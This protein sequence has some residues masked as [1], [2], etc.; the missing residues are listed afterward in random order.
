MYRLFR[1][2]LFKLGEERA[3]RVG[4]GAARLVQAVKPDAIEPLFA[5]DHEALRQTCWGLEFPNPVGLAAGF[6]KNARLTRFW[7][8]VGFGFAEVGSVS[9]RPAE[10]NPR[11]RAFRLPDDHAIINRMGLNNEGAEKIAERLHQRPQ[12]DLAPLGI[13]LAKT[14]DPGIMG[15]AAVDDFCQS[16]HAL[17]P[18]ADYVALNISCPNTTEG[19]TFEDPEALEALLSAIFTE[20]KAMDLDVPV[21]LKLSPPVSEH[22]VFDSA[23]EETLSLAEQYGIQGFIATNTT[24]DRTG[25]R[26]PA[27]ELDQIGRG[28]LSGKPLEERA[29]RLIRQIYQRT[30]GKY[31]IIGVGGVDSAPSA[32]AKIRAGASLVQLY[33]A[34]VYEGPGVVK[35]IKQNLVRLLKKDGFSSLEEAVGVDA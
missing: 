10:G 7:Q 1:P 31:P 14:H 13:N 2:L 33:T 18:L 19:K 23:M 6:D 28:G 34:L 5:F 29:T 16:F 32:Y 20:R 12:G 8:A 22:V 27:E 30:K 4:M 17:A 15:T 24:S 35:R 21:L 3:H 11:P 9:A 26:T 25:L